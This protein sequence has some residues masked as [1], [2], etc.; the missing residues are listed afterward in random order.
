[1][2]HIKRTA[3]ASF[4]VRQLFDLVNAVERYP[5]FLPWCSQS[6]IVSRT[7]QTIEA[8]LEIAWGGMRKSFTTRNE[9][10]PHDRIDIVLVNGPFRELKGHWRF[11]PID[12]TSCHVILDLEFDVGGRLIDKI[13]QP[14][15]HG[16][17]D[18]LVDI[19]CKRAEAIY[20]PIHT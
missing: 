10:H 3:V 20:Q 6:H 12:E 4:S 14:I 13:F 17:A 15:F 5:D 8:T 19:F 18:S 2:A 1:M 16:I 7:E 11:I 9:L